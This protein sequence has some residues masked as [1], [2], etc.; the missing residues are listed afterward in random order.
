MTQQQYQYAEKIKNQYVAEEESKID[1]L[2]ALDKKVK[3]PSKIFAWAF[4]AAGTLVLGVGMCV[5]MSVIN[6]PFV[7]GVIIGL[8]GIAAVCANYPIYKLTLKSRKNK[9][10]DKVIALSDEIAEGRG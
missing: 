5:A 7:W 2:K 10:A 8:V 4:G 6:A 3:R 9:Y 1:A